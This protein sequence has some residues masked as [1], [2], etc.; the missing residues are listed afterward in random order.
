MWEAMILAQKLADLPP[1]A[2]QGTKRILNMHVPRALTG[3]MQTGFILEE[4]TMQTEEHQ[5]IL[6]R[7]KPKG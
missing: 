1:L 5:N 3:A 4:G 6:E 2:V 7:M